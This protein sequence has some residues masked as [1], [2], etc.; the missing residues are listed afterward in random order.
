MKQPLYT[1]ADESKNDDFVK[2]YK[3]IL[4]MMQEIDR[5]AYSKLTSAAKKRC[6]D[7]TVWLADNYDEYHSLTSIRYDKLNK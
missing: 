5:E 1:K 2:H 3:N 4:A 7:L 6:D